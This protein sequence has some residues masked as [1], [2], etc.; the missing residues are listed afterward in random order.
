MQGMLPIHYAVECG[1][2]QEMMEVLL[3]FGVKDA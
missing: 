3:D 2:K 1:A